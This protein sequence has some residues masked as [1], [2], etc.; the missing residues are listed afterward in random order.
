MVITLFGGH[1]HAIEHA[2]STR[3]LLL[4]H[5]VKFGMPKDRELSG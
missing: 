2:L 4:D 5:A 1:D 3:M